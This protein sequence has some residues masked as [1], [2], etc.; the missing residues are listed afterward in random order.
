VNGTAKILS[1]ADMRL[2]QPA[3]SPDTVKKIQNDSSIRLA[4]AKM[5]ISD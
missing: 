1:I 2:S 4:S 5:I 3:D